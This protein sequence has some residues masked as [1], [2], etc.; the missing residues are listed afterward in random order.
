MIIIIDYGMGNLASVYNAF[1]KV[2]DKNED[3]KISSDEKLIRDADKLILPG[4]GAFG[5]AMKNL[6][7]FKLVYPILD[8]INKNK[9][10]LGICLGF[11][12]LFKKSYENG[13][14]DGL[15]IIKGEVVRFK[16]ELP[17]PHMG[18]NTVKVIKRKGIFENINDNSFFYFDHSYYP[19][20]EDN[21]TVA[22]LTNYNN[23]FVSGICYNN[24]YGVQFH[25]EKSH[26]NGLKI[27]K[28]FL[29]Q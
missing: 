23:E 16:T 15:G 12:L 27:V 1:I 17:I 26:F 5:D 3:I 20:L 9:F 2:N 7:K 10:F 13:V 8:H 29:N 24:I 4:V 21:E 6:E 14:F 28:S 22:T 25:P 11:Q 19:I 18:W